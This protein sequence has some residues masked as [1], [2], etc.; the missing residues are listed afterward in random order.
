MAR[1]L[2]DVGNE[3]LFRLR[4]AESRDPL[5]LAPLNPL[6]AL[7]LLGLL[8]H[9]ALAVFERL[10][11]PIEVPP[12]NLEGLGLSKRTLLHSRDLRAARLQLIRRPSARA[13][14]LS[15]VVSRRTPPPRLK[16]RA[17]LHRYL[18]SAS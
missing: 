12:L 18:P 14:A 17:Y 9:V 13:R 7:E 11:A 8:L 16:Q 4:G 1:L 3:E 15:P 6:G 5:E 2:L 10:K